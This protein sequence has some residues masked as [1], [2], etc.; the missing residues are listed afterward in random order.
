MFVGVEVTGGPDPPGKSKV[1]KGFLRN[2]GL[3]LPTPTEFP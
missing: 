2:T 3:D 1:T